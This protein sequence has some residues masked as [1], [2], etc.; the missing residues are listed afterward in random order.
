MNYFLLQKMYLAML[1]AIFSQ[2]HL[3]TLDWV[4]G[5]IPG[6][7]RASRSRSG[8]SWSR[9][10]NWNRCL[11][12]F[13]ILARSRF[14]IRIFRPKSL[15]STG[16]SRIPDVSRSNRCCDVS[17]AYIL[18]NFTQFC[19]ILRNVTQFYGILRNFTQ[20]LHHSLFAFIC[21]PIK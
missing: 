20:C 12:R 15:P 4:L 2:T 21:C 1:W 16:L 10:R 11:K 18:R 5:S 17:Y 13:R 6:H 3:V 7:S 9:P 14:R 8:R 19:A